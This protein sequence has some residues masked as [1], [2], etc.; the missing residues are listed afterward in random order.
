[1]ADAA[2]AVTTLASPTAESVFEQRKRWGSKTVHYEKKQAMVLGGIF[3]FYVSTALCFSGGFFR[4][5]LF[6]LFGAMMAVKLAGE[7][8]LMIPGMRIFNQRAPARYFIPA[9]IIHLPVVLAAVFLGVFGRFRWKGD[10]YS[11]RVS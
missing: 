9:S 5:P 11:R 1:M 6:A 2:G 10:V 4:P 8:F 7:A 3:L